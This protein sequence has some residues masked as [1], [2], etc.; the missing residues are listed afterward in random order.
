MDF[1]G[2]TP[3]FPSTEVIPKDIPREKPALPLQGPNSGILFDKETE[4]TFLTAI[5]PNRNPDLDSNA[6]STLWS[7]EG[8]EIQ[9]WIFLMLIRSHLSW[10]LFQ[11]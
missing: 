3:G 5:P 8:A 4:L 11:C 2:Q 1:M 7:V 6:A 10:D 9:L